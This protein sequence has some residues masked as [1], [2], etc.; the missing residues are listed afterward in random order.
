VSAEHSGGTT[1]LAVSV[2]RRFEAKNVMA[3]LEKPASG[4][5]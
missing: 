2:S 1:H 5:G 3:V 4:L